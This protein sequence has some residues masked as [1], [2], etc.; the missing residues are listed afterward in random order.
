MLVAKYLS[1]LWFLVAS[2][3]ALGHDGIAASNE[4]CY[5]FNPGQMNYYVAKRFCE[6]HD[7]I[8]ASMETADEY[9]GFFE[10]AQTCKSSC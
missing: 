4:L 3:F 2:S 6:D 1:I 9:Q 8:L 5:I 10:I 7:M